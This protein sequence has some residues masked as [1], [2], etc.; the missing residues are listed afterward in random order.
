MPSKIILYLSTLRADAVSKTYLCPNGELIEGIQ[1]NEAPVLYL[2]SEHTSVDDILC[3]VTPQAKENAWQ[4]FQNTISAKYPQIKIE[5]LDYSEEENFDQTVLPAILSLVKE[6]DEI[7]LDITGGFRTDIIRIL[8]LSRVLCYAGARVVQAVY[9]NFQACRIEDSTHLFDSFE[10]LGGLQELSDGV[11]VEKLRM[12]YSNKPTDT[13]ITELL[14]ATEA[15][16]EAIVLCRSGFLK[17]R[18]GSFNKALENAK[19]CDDPLLRTILP[20]FRRKFGETN[21][22]ALVRWCVKNN[23]LQAAATVYNEMV[24]GFLLR[25]C[26]E[27]LIYVGNENV[28]DDEVCTKII[29]AD[30]L[31]LAQSESLASED[32]VQTLRSFVLDNY[33]NIAR[34]KPLSEPKSISEA[35]ENIQYVLQRAY[36][37]INGPY[38]EDWDR[39][40]KPER[41][42]LRA[43]KGHF[44][45]PQKNKIGAVKG[46]STIKPEFASV[47]FQTSS[48]NIDDSTLC[49][50]S[51][52]VQQNETYFLALDNLEKTLSTNENFQSNDV[53]RLKT[54]LRDYL[55]IRSVRN[56]LNHA[57]TNTNNQQDKIQ[58]YLSQFGYPKLLDL[59]S[60]DIKRI[61][62]ESA[63]HLQPR[64]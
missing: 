54:I 37:N 1:T 60:D 19:S 34:G 58:E 25:E 14:D 20:I 38:K 39:K 45:V 4:H 22:I 27:C 15:L 11:N 47:L 31:R 2:L 61:L 62:L 33:E 49:E 46:F 16:T 48:A 13:R 8:L 44:A 43:L 17:E 35:I 30:L 59:H 41:T 63:E 26:K 57:S 28:Q 12:Y 7:L 18:L 40:L 42:Y 51:T 3:V 21:V 23:M 64:K 29:M 55:F 6:D 9:G 5:C 53:E 36:P 52:D 10:L 32:R 24:P 56:L 50:D